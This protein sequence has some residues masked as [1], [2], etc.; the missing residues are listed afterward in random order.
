MEDKYIKGEYEVR[1]NGE[2]LG[3]TNPVDDFLKAKELI[4]LNSDCEIRTD[5]YLIWDVDID[6]GFNDNIRYHLN[7]RLQNQAVFNFKLTDISYDFL[8]WIKACNIWVAFMD[9]T[10]GFEKYRIEFEV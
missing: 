10:G 8:N 5:G 1:T 3:Y 7:K 6:N 2:L 4:K 9:Q